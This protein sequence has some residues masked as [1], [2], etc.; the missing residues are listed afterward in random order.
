MSQR[1]HGKFEDSEFIF[2]PFS[3]IHLPEIHAIEQDVY[4]DPWSLPLIS[5]S[6][7]A[8]MTHCTGIFLKDRCIGYAIYQVIFTEGHLLNI[9]IHRD[10]QTQGLGGKLLEKV[11][12]DSHE[13]GAL[14]FFLEVRPTNERARKIYEKRGFRTLM[15]RENY[16]ANGEDAILMVKDL[17]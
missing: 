16:Y 12:K 6:L 8:S 5:E 10:F 7:T 14:Y 4:D 15:T 17:L 2:K 1:K 9:A 3:A 13:L 11:M